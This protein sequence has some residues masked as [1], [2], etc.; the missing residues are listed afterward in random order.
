M[1]SWATLLLLA[2]ATT[3]PAAEP[4]AW[5]IDGGDVRVTCA[6]TVG[7]SFDVKSRAVSGRL[8]DP[9]AT[10]PLAGTVEVDLR[11]LDSGIGLRNEHMLER[12]LEVQRGAGF[13]KAVIS[14]LRLSAFDPER[15]GE[16]G[17]EGVLLLH[18]V[19][20]GIAG[21][22]RLRGPLTSP[23]AEARFRVK[24]TD[25]GIPLPQHLGIGVEDEVEI[26]VSFVA[27]PE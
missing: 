13:D 14:D 11:T 16:T 21:S 27:T 17:F 24:L 20:K 3:L 8:A 9:R 6:L 23:R 18:N 26:R 1:K 25:Y 4:S 12:Y 22:V 2:G 19:K 5:R 15:L 10:P 7:G